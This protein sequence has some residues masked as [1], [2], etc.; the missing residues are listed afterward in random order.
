MQDSL[1]RVEK[2]KKLQLL[3]LQRAGGEERRGAVAEE[4]LHLGLAKMGG[5]NLGGKWME[6]CL[7][8]VFVWENKK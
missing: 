7:N 4:G 2:L 5:A 1:Q 6:T 3:P 8:Q